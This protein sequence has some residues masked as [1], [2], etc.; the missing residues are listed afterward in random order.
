[1][2]RFN[3]LPPERRHQ[4]KTPI[5]RLLAIY[6]SVV[7]SLILLFWNLHT[8]IIKIGGCRKILADKKNELTILKEATRDFD[9]VQKEVVNLNKR[10]QII[11]TIKSSRAFLWWETIDQLLD[12]ICDNPRVW[13]T[14]LKGGGQSGK[15]RGRSGQG[16]EAELAF[17]CLSAGLDPD[18]MTKFRTILKNHPGLTTVFPLINE[19]PEFE[20]VIMKDESKEGWAL[21]FD[22]EL[23][24]I[25]QKAKR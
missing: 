3:L 4:D 5:L 23:S 2:L 13:I 9:V 14:S 24:R 6:S 21:R 8:Y 7:L 11:E 22:I 16:I 15:S 20:A 10:T 19:P 25:K 18:L 1:M 17:D 12:V